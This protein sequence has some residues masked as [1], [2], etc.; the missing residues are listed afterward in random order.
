M[1]CVGKRTSVTGVS[2]EIPRGNGL[3]GQN[4]SSL[5]SSCVK[6]IA[7]ESASEDPM[8]KNNRASSDSRCIYLASI[9]CQAL[10]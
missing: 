2:E 8:M 1:Q 3:R 7:E 9:M 5:E 4:E 10:F 6:K